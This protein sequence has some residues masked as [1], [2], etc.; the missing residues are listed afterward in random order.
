MTSETDFDM[1]AHVRT[2]K[3]FMKLVTW[4]IVLIAITLGGMALF[5]I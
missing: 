1:E 3:G 4:A 2:W 5:L